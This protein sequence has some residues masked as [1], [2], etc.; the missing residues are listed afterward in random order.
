VNT[1]ILIPP[2]GDVKAFHL[3]SYAKALK[4]GLTLRS[5]HETCAD[6]NAWWPK[7]VA[8]RERVGKGLIEDGI[9]AGKPLTQTLEQ[10]K[11]MRQ[12]MTDDVENK[13]LKAFAE[14]K[15]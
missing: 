8:R 7:E 15:K 6:T 11:A 13:I 3:R 2:Q 1:T 5:A 10:L 4:A 14:S 12:G 9:K